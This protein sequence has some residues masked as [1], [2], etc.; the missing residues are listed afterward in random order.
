MAHVVP[1]LT[2]P[3]DYVVDDACAG[4]QCRDAG[5][6]SKAANEAASLFKEQLKLERDTGKG[7]I[8]G[9]MHVVI[10]VLHGNH[11]VT[12]QEGSLGARKCN[13]AIRHIWRLDDV[14]VYALCHLLCGNSHT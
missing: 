6:Q 3:T 5:W 13:T 11:L 2:T 8:I 9:H 12:S 7:C 4:L 1:T 14:D 10:Y